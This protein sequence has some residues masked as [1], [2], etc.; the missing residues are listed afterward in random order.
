M[1]KIRKKDFDYFGYFRNVGEVITEAADYLHKTVCEFDYNTFSDKMAEM[2]VIE[3]KADNIK[4]EMVEHLAHEFITPIERED[5]ISLSQD[6]DNVVDCID[7]VV[8]CIYMYNVTEIRPEVTE[9]TALI[10]KA[11]NSLR[12]ALNE[13]EKFKTKTNIKT[14]IVDVNHF[15][16]DG[17]A[18]LAQSLRKLYSDGTSDRNVI[19]WTNVI[20]GLEN[21]LDAAEDSV[22]IIESVIMKNT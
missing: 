8:R 7:D 5:I 3:N 14:H 20:S 1:A 13:F 18:L 15:E 16:N 11:C 4:H 17:D 19:I 21:C 22:D 9:F 10:V 6:L 12:E 2:H